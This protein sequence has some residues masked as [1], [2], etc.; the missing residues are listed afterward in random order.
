[1]IEP[2]TI[3]SEKK[4]G[5]LPEKKPPKQKKIGKPIFTPEIKGRKAQSKL[6]KKVFLP[7]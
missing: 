5:L 7:G 2:K 3:L 1:V 4:Y 6:D